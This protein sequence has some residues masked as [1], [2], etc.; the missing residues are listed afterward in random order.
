MPSI[1]AWRNEASFPHPDIMLVVDRTGE[2]AEHLHY[3][4]GPSPQRAAPDNI[5]W[6]WHSFLNWMLFGSNVLA[7][8]ERARALE[9]LGIVHRYLL[10]L[11]R[12]EEG[13]IEHWQTPSK[14]AE[15][16]LSPAAYAHFAACTANLHG[17][18]LE[19]AYAASWAWGN[20]LIR[21]LAA[22]HNLNLPEPLIQALDAHLAAVFSTDIS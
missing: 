1:R 5:L 12:L 17:D 6:L 7:R 13:T 8:G 10:W 19:Q 16:D 9:L 3:L 14:S 21:I 2:L 15:A 20:D 4:S 22:R 18:S 11:A